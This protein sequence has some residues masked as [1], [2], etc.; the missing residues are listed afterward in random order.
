[1]VHFEV[2]STEIVRF[3]YKKCKN[4]AKYLDIIANCSIFAQVKLK[5]QFVLSRWPVKVVWTFF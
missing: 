3:G 2:I 5:Q 4:L 1:M